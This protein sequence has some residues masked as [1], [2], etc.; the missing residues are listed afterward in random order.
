M[1]NDLLGGRYRLDT[2]LGRGGMAA[3][4]RAVDVRLDRPVAVKVLDGAALTEPAAVQRFHREARTVARLTDPHVVSVYDV[5]SD[6]DRHY[7]VMELVRGRSL[8]ELLTSGALPI[9]GAVGIAVQ[10]CEALAAAHSAGVVHRDVKP[11]NILVDDK[12]RVKVCDFG[13][14]RLVGAAQPTLTAVGAVI[15]TSHYM[16]PEQVAGGPVDARTDLYAL[17]CVLYAMLTGAP[18]FDGQDALGVAWQQLHRDPEP[19]AA[20]RPDVSAPLAALVEQLLA[21]EPQDRPRSATQVRA[22]LVDAAAAD[23]AADGAAGVA[24]DPATT[25]LAATGGEGRDTTRPAAA[26]R[27]S[28]VVPTPTR[29]LPVT[30]YDTPPPREWASRPSWAA[31]A[32]ATV[33]ALVLVGTLFLLWENRPEHRSQATPT[34]VVTTAPPTAATTPAAPPVTGRPTRPGGG[35]TDRLTDRVFDEIADR[36]V[37]ARQAV[38]AATE[39]GRIDPKTAREIDKELDKL[40]RE[41]AEGDREKVVEKSR[42]VARKLEKLR[43]EGRISAADW[44]SVWPGLGTLLA[45][46]PSDDDDE[47]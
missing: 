23:G 10:V 14:A 34:P 40:E 1:S 36:I 9:A 22:A 45:G 30:A 5:G 31:P 19:V 4:W 47:D 12:G 20:R 3:V 21:K 28:A 41:L 17:G 38:A 39:A 8:A 13:I 18:P 35:L 33:A 25:V 37:A 24:A 42:D 46:S 27:A 32:A 11:G 26:V 7:L 15:G 2:V 16:A 44:Q 29:A 43:R 6:A